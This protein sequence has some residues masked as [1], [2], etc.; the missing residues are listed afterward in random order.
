MHISW[1]PRWSK[2]A[3]WSPLPTK[4]KMARQRN[5]H[6]MLRRI[7]LRFVM[8]FASSRIRPQ[9]SAESAPRSHRSGAFDEFCRGRAYDGL[10]LW[11]QGYT[12]AH[13]HDPDADPNPHDQRIQVSFNDG[14]AGVGIQSFVNQIKV[15][16]RGGADA[17]N[18]LRLLAGLVEA[19]LGIH[20]SNLLVALENVDD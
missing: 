11:D 19:P 16:R 7:A 20:R 14:T 8:T 4:I 5:P 15:F 3:A 13:D 12:R 18:G 17:W 10:R 2:G 9:S 6:C 1:W